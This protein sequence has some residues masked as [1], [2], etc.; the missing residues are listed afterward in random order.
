VY[1]RGSGK[2]WSRGIY[3]RLREGMERGIYIIGSG[4]GRIYRGE[5]ERERERDGQRCP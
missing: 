2:A 3:K 1:I 4:S 5:R